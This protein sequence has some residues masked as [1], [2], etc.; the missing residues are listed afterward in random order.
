[1]LRCIRNVIFHNILANLCHIIMNVFKSHQWCHSQFSKM[2]LQDRFDRFNLAIE[3]QLNTRRIFHSFFDLIISNSIFDF[4]NVQFFVF[5]TGVALLEK[6]ILSNFDS[7]INSIRGT[8][9]I[10]NALK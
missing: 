3:L 1:M 2:V 7:I 8:P 5:V 6:R 4:Q 9:A 10:S